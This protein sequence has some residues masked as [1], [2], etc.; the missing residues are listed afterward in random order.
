LPV[1]LIDDD[2]VVREA[3]AGVLTEWGCDVRAAAGGVAAETCLLNGPPPRLII[4]DYRLGTG[5]NG[6]DVVRKI[7]VQLKHDVPAVI[8][9]AEASA[10]LRDTA[11]A[12]GLHF[13]H[14]PLN[15]ARLRALLIHVTGAA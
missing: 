2:A 12:A 10:E 7:R 1:L 4:C 9:S 6:I 8:I 14:K 15:A 11:T 5:E 3:T 13:L